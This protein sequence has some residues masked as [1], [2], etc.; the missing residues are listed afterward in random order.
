MP[1]KASESTPRASRSAPRKR[2]A[3]ARATDEVEVLARAAVGAAEREVGQRRRGRS[4]AGVGSEE[5][6]TARSGRRRTLAAAQPTPA[7]RRRRS[8]PAESAHVMTR[9]RLGRGRGMSLEH[10]Q[11]LAEGR[12]QG[13]D[14]RLYLEALHKNRP[15]RGRK[16]TPESISKRLAQLEYQLETADPVRKLRLVQERIDLNA[17]L[18]KLQT[19]NYLTDLKERFIAVAAA[20][21][22]RKGITYSA[23]RELGVPADVLRA[24]GIRR[25]S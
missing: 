19:S 7:G 8:V 10:K 17:E 22:E 21:G 25:S 2:T 20:Y 4:V 15:K 11:A 12:A 14:V 23:W 13:R 3:P 6:G 1:R 5:T 16:R 9:S 18:E 24:A